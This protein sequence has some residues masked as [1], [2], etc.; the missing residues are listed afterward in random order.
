[1][2]SKYAKPLPKVT[3][4]N[5]PFWSYT[6]QH[7]LRFKRCLDCRRWIYPISP[8]C[9]GCW[10]ENHE[11]AQVSGKG[12]VT[13]WVTYRKA[14]EDSFRPDLPYTVIQVDLLEGFRLISNFIDPATKPE[15]GMR[16]KVAFDDVTPEI[17]LVKFAPD[18]D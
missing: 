5:A 9:Q 2:E 13:S 11:W 4:L 12:M 10:S 15:Y 3:P 7:D 18:A 14:F 16:V 6:H 17:T 8:L 1:M